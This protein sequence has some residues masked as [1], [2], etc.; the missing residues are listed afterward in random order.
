MY[1]V[2]HIPGKKIGVTK[3]PEYRIT[4]QQ[5]YSVGEYEIL[6]QSEDIDYVSKLEVSLQELHGYKID[7]TLY[8]DLKP[9]KTELNSMKINVTEQTTTFPCPVNKLKGQLMDNLDVHWETE[10]GVLS[11]STSTIQWILGNVKASYFNKERCFV[12]NKAFAKFIGETNT[13]EFDV[14]L[15]D[16]DNQKSTE[17]PN[18]YDLIRQWASARGIYKSGDV[19]TQYVKLMEEAGEL[20]EAILKEDEDETI[21]AIGDMMVV[22]TNLAA[23]KGYK[24]EECIVTAYEVIKDRQGEMVNGTFVKN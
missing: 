2:Y 17:A 9:N 19:N 12:Y 6:H 24:V 23:M 7:T 10:H 16:E 5:G 14:K 4:K 20:A 3:N 15:E 11:I 13:A 21:D 18:V 22:L 8:K 1:Y